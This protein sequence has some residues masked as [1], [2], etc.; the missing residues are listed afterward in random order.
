MYKTQSKPKSSKDRNTNEAIDLKHLWT[1]IREGP[2]HYAWYHVWC[3]MSQFSRCFWNKRCQSSDDL[4]NRVLSLCS[5]YRKTSLTKDIVPWASSYVYKLIKGSRWVLDALVLDISIKWDN[6]DISVF[7]FPVLWLF[8][9]WLICLIICCRPGC[10]TICYVWQ[11]HGL[12]KHFSL[13]MSHS[14]GFWSAS[15]HFCFL[16]NLT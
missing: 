6:D 2:M 3:I 16:W 14:A 10:N 1:L 7:L 8:V 15:T 4:R 11:D 12:H 9:K 5:F 13:L